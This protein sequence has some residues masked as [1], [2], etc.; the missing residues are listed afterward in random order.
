M[1]DGPI[2]VLAGAVDEEARTLPARLPGLDVRLLTPVD[3]SRPGWEFRPG[4]ADAIAVVDGELISTALTAVLVR[5][6]WVG[7]HDL[8]HIDAGDRAYVAAEMTALLLAWLSALPCPVVN[9]PSTTCL[10]GPLWRPERWARLAAAVGLS[11]APV[12][13][14]AGTGATP[15]QPP[16]PTEDDGATVTVVGS[17]CLGTDDRHV[18]S[19]LRR[20][21][22]HA[23]AEVLTVHLGETG[24]DARFLGASPWARLADDAVLDAILETAGVDA[25]AAR[26]V[27]AG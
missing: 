3:L 19:L 25:G 27:G 1:T 26:A 16:T 14:C 20:L 11:V 18:A 9:R 23:G 7:E 8:P 24:S 22:R 21:A 5:L 17:R 4:H 2:V 15:P 13:R 12:Q 6:P 10:A